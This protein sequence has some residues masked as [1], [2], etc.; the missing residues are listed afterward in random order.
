MRNLAKAE[1][2]MLQATKVEPNAS[3]SWYNLANIQAFQGHAADAAESLKK[4][5]AA[6]ALERSS[7]PRMVDLRDLTPHQ[8]LF[9]RHPAN[10]RVPRRRGHQL[11]EVLLLILILIL[12]LISF[13]QGD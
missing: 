7:N 9:Q 2:A 11:G 13:A 3:Q 4:A 1:E 12:I 10:P 5:F 8:S 6:N